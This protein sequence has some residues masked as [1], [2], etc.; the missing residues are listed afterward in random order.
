MKDWRIS[1]M[2]KTLSGLIRAIFELERLNS[3]DEALISRETMG[4]TRKVIFA[5]LMEQ[6][7]RAYT[8]NDEIAMVQVRSWSGFG[9]VK[10]R[11]WLSL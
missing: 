6:I 5:G 11:G 4:L 7:I 2:Y 9:P 8:L 3:N 10:P 1:V